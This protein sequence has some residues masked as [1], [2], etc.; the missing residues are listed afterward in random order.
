[1]LTIG[2]VKDTKRL[3]ADL[4]S[5]Y[6]FENSKTH[7]L[8]P[9]PDPKTKKKVESNI[10]NF[11]FKGK[12]GELLVLEGTDDI[13]RILLVGMGKKIDLSADKVRGV[14]DQAIKKANRL[15]VESLVSV[16]PAA[17]KYLVNALEG[18]LLS[19]YQ[20]GGFFQKEDTDRRYT[21]KRLDF[22][23]TAKNFYKIVNETQ[24]LFSAV[25]RSKDLVNT[26]SNI[27][28]PSYLELEARDIA[29]KNK[30]VQLTVLDEKDAEQLKM[31]SFLAVGR[32]SA[33]PSK[34]IILNY[35]G[36]PKSK[37]L[38]G[39][40]GKGITFDSGGISIK[41]GHGMR[42]MKADMAGSAA[43]LG[44]FRAVS[45]LGLKIN[46]V[47]IVAA[48]ENMPGSRAYKPGDVITASN[49][50][51]I[52]ITNTDAE[53]RMVLADA[54]VY[55]Q[56][57]GATKLVD[58]ATLTGA[59]ITALGNVRTALMSNSEEWA[60]AYLDSSRHTGEKTWQLPMDDEFDELLKSDICDMIN[61]NENKKAG[62]I[63]GGKFLEKFI[64][65]N[66]EWIHLDIAGTAYLDAPSGYLHKN[67]TAVTVRTIVNLLRNEAK[68][69]KDS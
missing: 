30:K 34:M 15:K 7:D 51:T 37:Q 33:E 41:P 1:M 36:N 19:S 12:S 69:K 57:L 55:A 14:L 9:I 31:Y 58:I 62:T 67:A 17:D 49:G 28:T 29:G 65:K 26:P 6:L 21:L 20:F 13:K 68:G 50:K 43:A 54:L 40:I 48:A 39:V 27:V 63:V 16:I 5:I 44:V 3:K 25:N 22:V 18:A 56:K 24:A 61:A 42:M 8:D 10:K 64:E 46:L 11:H 2:G 66:T 23:T 32:G 60:E 47:T 59:C 38:Y 35:S 52:E 53:G 45:N 4:L